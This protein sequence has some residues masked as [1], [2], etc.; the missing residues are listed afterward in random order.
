M[1]A[2]FGYGS[3]MNR[4]TLAYDLTLRAAS[5]RGW[6]RQWRNPF[7]MNGVRLCFLTVHP[8]QN[9]L[10]RGALLSDGPQ[11]LD[12]IITEREHSDVI[13]STPCLIDGIGTI[14]AN[15][16]VAPQANLFWA[17]ANAPIHLSYLDCVLQGC[18]Q[19]YGPE[20]INEFITTTEGW[21]LPLI[22]DRERPMYT[23]SVRLTK[24]DV[25]LID[26]CLRHHDLL[27]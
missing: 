20:G 27:E 3:L 19:L 15:L 17:S 1:Q 13:V 16:Y 6:V 5:I 26:S 4:S 7:E 10:L 11:E 12:R 18:Q 2:V 14:N 22:D 24:K 25:K 8:R 9:F 21:Y 23:R